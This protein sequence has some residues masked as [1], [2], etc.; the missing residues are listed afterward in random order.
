VPTATFGAVLIMAPVRSTMY[1]STQKRG[2]IIGGLS[3]DG[4]VSQAIWRFDVKNFSSQ[5]NNEFILS[6]SQSH[7][8]KRC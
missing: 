1:P 2:L 6:L 3:E 7:F 4:L 8:I 5:V